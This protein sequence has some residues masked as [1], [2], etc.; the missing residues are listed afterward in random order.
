MR[1][2]RAL[3]TVAPPLSRITF[4]IPVRDDARRLEHCLKS[5]LADGNAA[6]PALIVIDN[7]STDDS[8]AVARRLGAVVLRLDGN[9]AALRNAGVRQASTPLVAFVDADH[10][11]LP[12]WLAAAAA[13]FDDG[14]IGAAGAPCHAPAD[15]TWVQLTYDGLRRHPERVEPAEWFGAG[16]LVVRRDAF[17]QVGGFDTGLETC[18]DVDLSAKLRQAGWTLLSVPAMRNIHFGD[19]P[20][21]QRL[22]RSELWRGRDNLRVSLRAPWSFRNTVSMAIPIVQ[23]AALPLALAA[24][25]W[26]W[27]LGVAVLAVPLGLVLLRALSLQRNTRGRNPGGLAAAVAVAAAYDAGRALALVARAGHHRGRN[28]APATT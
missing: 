15:G 13:A 14:A 1:A 21:L 22:F 12:G 19:P 3:H 18:E 7:G 20:T 16:N 26:W 8:A 28:A 27:P 2:W 9:V 6:P 17:E 4:V 10:E 25:W 5:I 24:A 11:V 23:L